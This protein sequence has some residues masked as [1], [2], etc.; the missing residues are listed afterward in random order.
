MDE[1]PNGET[2]TTSK[3]KNFGIAFS[4]PML[5]P[6]A[7]VEF[8]KELKQVLHERNVLT[9]RTKKRVFDVLDE[10]EVNSKNEGRARKR[11]NAIFEIIVSEKSYVHQLSLIIDFFMK[12]AK[13][14]KLLSFEDYEILFG[15]IQTIYS[16][17]EALLKELYKGSVNVAKAFLHIAPYFKMYSSYA[18]GFKKTLDFLQ[19]ARQRNPEFYNFMEK[20]ETR[21]E[22][23]NKLSALLIAP[24][25]R[26][27]RYKLL[28]QQLHE[29][30]SPS[31]P[32]YQSIS[33]SLFKVEEAAKHINKVVEDQENMQRLLE[34]QRCIKNNQPSIIT[35]GRVLLK[36]GTLLQF[37]G[38]VGP[39]EKF[40]VILL[41]DI[42]LFCKMKS[43]TLKPNSL[44]C[45]KIFPLNKCVV[46]E[47]AEKGCF[48]I[49]C[50]GEDFILYDRV[51]SVTKDWVKAT[52]DA[53][54]N[55]IEKR[56]TLRKESS[57]RKPVK[58]REFNEYNDIGLS[59][60]IPLKRRRQTIEEDIK[61]DRHFLSPRRSYKNYNLNLKKNP[62]ECVPPVSTTTLAEVKL[63]DGTL[64]HSTPR[65]DLFV[66]GREN[67]NTSFTFKLTNMISNLSSSIFNIFKSRK[68]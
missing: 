65:T 11:E 43:N 56:K 22:V 28:L 2:P 1:V 50:E 59:P 46:I 64:Y 29:L 35:P 14:K 58:R 39:S 24:I 63:D 5:T 30:T 23:Q 7:N 9:T 45:K 17:N 41:N 52:N 20:Q 36:E 34:V 3:N 13:E 60:G 10:I 44:K 18:L 37:D 48:Q 27:P 19:K 67:A 12:P 32:D 15:N 4:S 26:V 16:V 38:K 8:S 53:I 6:K 42:I 68:D 51:L 21:P 62:A 31:E 66:F 33:D 61:T 47:N 40:Y 54:D 55:C 57:S 49:H 25:Q